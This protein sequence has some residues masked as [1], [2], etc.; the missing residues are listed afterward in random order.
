V[1]LHWHVTSLGYG[2]C[3]LPKL[4]DCQLTPTVPDPIDPP[5]VEQVTRSSAVD[6]LS[7]TKAVVSQGEPR[8]AAVNFDSINFYN[9]IVRF[10][11]HSTAFLYTSAT[12]QMPKL[13]SV[14]WFSGPCSKITAIAENHDARPKSR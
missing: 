3:T 13:H 10:L 5:I 8:D 9:G 4:A 7:E 11:C 12:I 2:Y 14:R 1:G 6:C